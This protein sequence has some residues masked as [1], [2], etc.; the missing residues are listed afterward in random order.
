M[1]VEPSNA[2]MQGHDVIAL[3][4]PRDSSGLPGLIQALGASRDMTL[5]RAGRI[6]RRYRLRRVESN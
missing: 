3:R 6:S 2:I 1:H 5:T 4:L